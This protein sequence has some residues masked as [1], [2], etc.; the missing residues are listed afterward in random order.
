MVSR[1]MISM[2]PKPV[3]TR[4]LSS[5]HPIPSRTYDENLCGVDAGE[6]SSPRIE[7]AR[8]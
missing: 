4:F 8:A 6:A 7:R 1:S 3:S 5:S 2:L